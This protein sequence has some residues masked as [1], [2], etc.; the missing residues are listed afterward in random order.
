MD[1]TQAEA[2][3][4]FVAEHPDGVIATVASDGKPQASVVYFSVDDKLQFFFTT[5]SST[6]KAQNLGDS[7]EVSIA[8]HDAPTQSVL[9][10][11][12]PAFRLTNQDEIMT[13]YRQTV[14]GAKSSGPDTVPPIAR[15]A[16]GEF[17]AFRIE[18]TFLDFVSYSQGDSFK[19]AMEHATD[20]PSTGDPS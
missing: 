15:I 5:K 13:V 18:P 20:Q 6:R 4:D 1:N 14:H 7:G 12:G 8:I 10:A 2:I 17:T 11:A 19:K 16:A 9:K 3:K